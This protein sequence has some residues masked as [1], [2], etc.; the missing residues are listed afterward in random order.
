MA[1]GKAAAIGIDLGGNNIKGVLLDQ[2]GKILLEDTHPTGDIFQDGPWQQS[3]KKFYENLYDK[4][5]ATNLP[6]GLSAPGLNNM[7]HSAILCMPGRFFGL[8]GLN[9]SK[10]LNANVKVLNDAHAATMA[11]SKL[12]A[13]K[14]VDNLVLLTLG[15]GVGGGIVIGGKLYQG[16]FQMAGHLGHIAVN[17]YAEERSIAGMPG[18]LED[19]IGDISVKR[20]SLGKFQNTAELVA[21]FEQGDTWAV[22]LWLDS[23]RKLALGICSIANGISPESI[24]LGGGIS[25]A[26][27]SLFVPLQDF[28]DLYE[29]RPAG[30]RT[31]VVP[32]HFLEYAGA[33][34]AAVFALEQEDL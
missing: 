31:T 21:A 34:G 14:G 32:A 29:W 16:F 30:K 3:V 25:K 28:L 8:E 24:I 12:G 5:G 22:Y 20:R 9:W 1:N 13:G 2:A 26:G 27:K 15:T 18:S 6:V 7:D 17:G 4:A 33:A 23:V 11:E 19:A 10:Y